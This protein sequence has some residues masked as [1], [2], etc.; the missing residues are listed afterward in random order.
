MA[1]IRVIEIERFYHEFIR[2]KVEVLLVKPKS[3]S[4]YLHSVEMI[5]TRNKPSFV[6]IIAAASLFF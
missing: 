4:M 1:M 3:T 2:V 6:S 5:L